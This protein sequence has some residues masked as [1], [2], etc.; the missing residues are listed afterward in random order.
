MP[1]PLHFTFYF[2]SISIPSMSFLGI[3]IPISPAFSIIDMLSLAMNPIITASLTKVDGVSAE[4]RH[5][6]STT[7]RVT[8]L[9]QS[10]LNPALLSRVPPFVFGLL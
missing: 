9:R 2:L 10:P 4:R 3:G 8:P 7:R 5:A 1:S 6:T